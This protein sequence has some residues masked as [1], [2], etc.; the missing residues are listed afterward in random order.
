MTSP[1]STAKAKEAALRLIKFR[2]RSEA[3]LA[4]RLHQK[5]FSESAIVVTVEELKGKGLVNDEKFSQYLVTGK[6]LSKPV[7]KRG[8]LKE[9][10]LKGIDDSLAARAVQKAYA[11]IDELE[12]AKT[13]ALSRMQRLQGLGK[14]AMS[15]RLFGFLSRRGF[16][17]E[18]VYRVVR[19][20]SP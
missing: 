3:E 10:A 20:L 13:A 6:L 5:G 16:S 2:P 19:E 7:G 14:E 8:L 12:L 17:S 9:L 4:A 18:T 1:E 15:R 11:Q